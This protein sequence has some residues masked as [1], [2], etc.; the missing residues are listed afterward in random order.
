MLVGVGALVVGGVVVG[1]AVVEVAVGLDGAEFEDGF[2]VG[3]YLTYHHTRK[4]PAQPSPRGST[5]NGDFEDYWNFHVAREHQRLYLSPDQQH[6][7]L[8]A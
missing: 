7:R 5:P 1:E 2:G 6:Y 8:T 4:T 3:D